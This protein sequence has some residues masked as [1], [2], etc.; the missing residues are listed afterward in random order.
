MSYH[1]YVTLCLVQFSCSVVS[2]SLWPHGLQHARPACPSPTPAVYSNSCPLRQWCH[3]T[4][5]SSVI[6]F[7]SHLQSFPAS[8]CFQMSQFWAPGGQS[9]EVSAPASVLP[10]NIQDWFPIGWT[11]WISVLS[12]GLSR[13]FPTPQFKTINS[14]V[15]SLRLGC[16][17][18]Q[19]EPE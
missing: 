15:L 13:V 16:T 4:I 14:S 2:D 18:M 8:A 10:M 19:W 5:F 9:V 17:Q 11:D 12:K 6:P 7:S 1:T 3:Q